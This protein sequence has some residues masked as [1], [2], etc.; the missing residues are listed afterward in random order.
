MGS[1]HLT[2]K[3]SRNGYLPCCLV[4]SKVST[5]TVY[6]VGYLSVFANITIASRYSNNTFSNLAVF[7]YCKAVTQ[8]NLIFIYIY[9]MSFLL[10]VDSVDS[11]HTGPWLYGSWISN[12][13]CNLCLSPLTL[14]VRILLTQG[15]LDTTLYN[16]VCQWLV[17]CRWFSPGTPVSSTNKT[18]HYDIT[19]ILLKVE[20]NYITL[21]PLFTFPW[22]HYYKL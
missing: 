2:I 17:P 15:V 14:W 22:C 1:I 9:L 19:E 4:N 20:L 11:I 8:T 16:I 13:L 10:T 12:Y 5:I 7:I 6:L 3:V 21:I 18:D